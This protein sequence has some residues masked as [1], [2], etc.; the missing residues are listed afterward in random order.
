MCLLLIDDNDELHSQIIIKDDV[1]R[2]HE[3]H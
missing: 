3:D 2:E 1:A